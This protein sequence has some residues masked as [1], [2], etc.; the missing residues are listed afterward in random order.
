MQFPVS[1]LYREPKLLKAKNVISLCR[2]F[3]KV[4]VLYREPKLLKVC[5]L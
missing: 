2:F 3:W 4:S 1:V 5:A